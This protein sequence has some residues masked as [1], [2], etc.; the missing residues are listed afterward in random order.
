MIVGVILDLTWNYWE[1]EF[2][3]RTYRRPP[4]SHATRWCDAIPLQS[5]PVGALLPGI[6]SSRVVTWRPIELGSQHG[7]R[8]LASPSC[9]PLNP[10]RCKLDRILYPA[11]TFFINPAPWTLP[12]KSCLSVYWVR[13]RGVW[14]VRR[15]RTNCHCAELSWMGGSYCV[16]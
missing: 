5:T 4:N 12:G 10:P 11:F 13:K 9:L 14:Y 8:L 3:V 16:W 15:I 1:P 2:P 7:Q 6:D